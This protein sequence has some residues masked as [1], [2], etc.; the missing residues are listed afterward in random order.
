MIPKELLKKIRRVQIRTSRTVNDVFAGHY[1]SAF[2]GL[3]MEFEEV[4]EYEPGDDIRSIDWNVTARQGRPFVKK[5]REERELTVMLTVDISG[6]NL[7]GTQ[8]Q[9]KRELAAEVS[10]TLA[11]SAIRN[12]DKVGLIC[13]SDRIE[14]FVPAKKGTLH[15]LRV[16]RE[17]LY[18][19]PAGT[20]TDIGLALE[21]L[22][23]VMR[24]RAVVFLIS[25]FQASG[26]EPAMRVAK[27]RHD[28]IPIIIADRREDEL[29][30][31]RFVELTDIE[32]GRTMLLDASGAAFR[33][34]FRRLADQRAEQRR[35]LF[36]RMDAEAIE[37][38]TGQSIVEPLTRF[39]RVREKRMAL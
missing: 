25:D 8:R 2:K 35:R 20:G 38:F 36:R 33:R 37:L 28:L 15:V 5:F 27:R 7:F 39:F 29:P 6:S 10:A 18:R 11:F 4:R 12:N 31:M 1:H 19:R 26:C 9:L 23:R 22:N 16:I 13:F 14:K 21:H 32:S 30:P 3:G 24:R 17:L 34:A